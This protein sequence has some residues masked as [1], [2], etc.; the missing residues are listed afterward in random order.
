M[1]GRI[2]QKS[3][4]IEPVYAQTISV[5]LNLHDAVMQIKLDEGGMGQRQK[6]YAMENFKQLISVF[7]EKRME[8]TRKSP[9]LK[10]R[11]LTR[12]NRRAVRD[13]VCVI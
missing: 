4:A 2:V 7:T 3:T 10:Q 9:P 11:F 12:C 8:A 5:L 6:E 1:K 13:A